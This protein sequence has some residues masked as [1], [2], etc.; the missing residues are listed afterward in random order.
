M[1]DAPQVLTFAVVGHP[2]EGK[3]S[4]VS[5]LT[6]DDTVRI[7]PLPGET[8]VCRSFPVIIDG[9]EMLRFVDTPGFQ[10]PRA[11]LEWLQAH[12]GPDM[13]ASFLRQN[14]GDPRFSGELELFRPLAEASST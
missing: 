5:T 9:R 1:T 13:L 3:S 6:E 7:T 10:S 2:N 11:T 4:V 14:A 8:V 12:A